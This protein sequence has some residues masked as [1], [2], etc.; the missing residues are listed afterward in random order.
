MQ[1]P[2]RVN[3]TVIDP[4]YQNRIM[5]EGTMVKIDACDIYYKDLNCLLRAVIQSNGIEKIELYNVCGQRYL[6]T[7]LGTDLGTN[8]QIDIHGTPGNDLAAFMSGPKVRVY[9][10]AQD[11]SGNT[12]NEG[13]IVIHG[14]AGDLT[15]HS[16]RGGKIFVRDY[17]GYRVGIH[18]KQYQRKVPTIV[19]GE[20][21][22]D[23]LAEYMAGGIILIL[24][25]SLKE[26]E[27]CRAR[28]VGTGMHGG[29]IYERGEILEPVE[30]TKTL[31]VGKRDMRIIEGLVKEYC[32]HFGC[33]PE[34]ILSGKFKKILPLSKRPYEK[35]YSH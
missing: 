7:D 24:G 34:Q 4:K 32:S 27:K 3:S 15:G 23:F 35:L 2:Q 33:D 30:G 18:M 29:V 26:C 25:L 17:V 28:F 8:I 11:A 5:H 16:M 22:G 21:A 13:E 1:Q 14:H 12:M 31:P 10:N 20:T 9:G 6:G 19:I